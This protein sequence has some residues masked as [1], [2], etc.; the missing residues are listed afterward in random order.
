M[1]INRRA[2]PFVTLA[3]AV[4]AAVAMI[5]C[6]GSTSPTVPTTLA[7]SGVTLIT[8]SIAA[9]SSGQGTVS[10]TAAAPTGGASIS[11]SSSNPAVAT[12]QTPLTIQAG[13]SSVTFTI[14]AV[15]AG[16]ATI[17]A[18]LNG[19]SSQSPTLTVTA[20]P[21]LASI[22]LSPSSVVGGHPVTGTVTLTAAAPVCCA[23]VSL[24][25]SGPFTVPASV[26]VPAG[27]A[28]ATFEIRTMAVGSTVTS[29]I[30]ASYA[31]VSKSAPLS[32]TQTPVAIAS[33]GVSGPDGSD[34]CT[35]ANEGNTLN[36]TFNG[37]G[38]TA[39]GNIIQWD[40]SYGVAPAMTSVPNQSVPTLTNPSFHCSL[41]PALPAGATSFVLIVKL[42]VRDD[43]GNV[44][45]EATDSGARILPNHL[46]GF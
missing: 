25:G 15:A 1:S 16:T 33:F 18:S 17:T 29:T 6:G 42:T 12:V 28:S 7:V 35:L 36:C 11:L 22:S 32:V 24:S 27:S 39:P 44:S 45:E 14:A 31:G 46:C 30:S 26:L 40:W 8:T 41:L 43:R 9:G 13:S 2:A 4:V 38:S 34:T 3:T 37:S 10:L 19:S 21:T 20:G 5:H 23:I